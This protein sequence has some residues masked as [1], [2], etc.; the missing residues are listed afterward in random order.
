MNEHTPYL[1]K[2][3]IDWLAGSNVDHLGVK[4]EVDA[5]LAITDVRA[6]KFASDI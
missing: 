1:N 5:L 6:D 2:S 3:I 4:D